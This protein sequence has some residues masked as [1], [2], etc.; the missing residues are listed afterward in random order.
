MRFFFFFGLVFVHFG[1]Y[2]VHSIFFLLRL[3]GSFAPALSFSLHRSIGL[4]MVVSWIMR[5]PRSASSPLHMHLHRELAG[6]AGLASRNHFTQN[7][8]L[9][10]KV[11]GQVSLKMLIACCLHEH[12]VQSQHFISFILPASYIR[13]KNPKH[14]SND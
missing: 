6:L 8:A 7:D 5:Q 1:F 14:T 11:G 10:F 3:L 4:D 12:R 2:S 13:K 9:Q